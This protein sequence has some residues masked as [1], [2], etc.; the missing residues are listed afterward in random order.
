M[1]V[2]NTKIIVLGPEIRGEDYAIDRDFN[3]PDLNILP[4]N[5]ELLKYRIILPETLPELMISSMIGKRLKEVMEIP[6]YQ[7]FCPRR[8]YDHAGDTLHN[9]QEHRIESI[10][11]ARRGSMLIVERKPT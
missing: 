9:I 10:R 7:G 11:N 3:N 6:Q 4:I 8:G 2:R 5:D 1:Y